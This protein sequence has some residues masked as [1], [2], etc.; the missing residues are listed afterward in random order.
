M[1]GKKPV[2]YL[3]KSLRYKCTQPVWQLQ[4][5]QAGDFRYNYEMVF[6]KLIPVEV[7]STFCHFVLLSGF[8]KI[9]LK[10]KTLRKGSS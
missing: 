9:K 4:F 5:C 6:L 8:Y 7:K 10:N 2:T 3:F 1:T